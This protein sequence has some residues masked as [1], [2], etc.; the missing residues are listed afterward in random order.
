MLHMEIERNNI[1]RKVNNL[2]N[3]CIFYKR[4]RN[5]CVSKYSLNLS[6]ANPQPYLIA[7]HWPISHRA[8]S[9]ESL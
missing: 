9:R 4:E 6:M 1:F 3:I 5:V 8:T 2:E 7:A